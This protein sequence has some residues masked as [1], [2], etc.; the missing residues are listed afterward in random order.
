MLQ[1]IFI[2]SDGTGGTAKQALKAALV[3]FESTEVETHLRPDVRS[4]DQVLDI[5]YEA[6]KIKGLI[7]HT[8]VSKKLRNLILEQGRLHD[9]LTID[10]MGPLLAQLSHYFENS[11]SERPGIY[12]TLNKAYFQRIEAVEFTLRH[13]DGQRVEELNNADIVLLGV[14]RTFKTPLSVYMSHKG[15][16]VANIPIIL[17]VPIPDIVY[18]LA[19]EKIFCLTTISS[20]L[21]ELRKVRDKH[22][23][24]LT[25]NYSERSYVHQ[26]LNYAQKI[27]RLH[28]K[29]TIVNVTNKPIEEI[30]SE[31][32]ANIRKK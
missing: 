9:L 19:P 32:L 7:I 26:E 27:F 14:S 18:D 10:L 11:P 6:Y 17:N 24:G 31:I 22:L 25:G 12:H 28:P 21:A 13:D 29:W 23:G 3:Q 5:I 15:W 1:H 4:E 2:V 20:R 16:R 8:I 30:S